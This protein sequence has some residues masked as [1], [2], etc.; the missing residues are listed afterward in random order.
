MFIAKYEHSSAMPAGKATTRNTRKKTTPL[1]QAAAQ[2]N[3]GNGQGQAG[4]DEHE[5]G[6]AWVRLRSSVL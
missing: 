6:S 2:A 5:D 3:G 1:E 4:L